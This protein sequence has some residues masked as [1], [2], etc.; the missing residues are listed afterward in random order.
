MVFKEIFGSRE[1]IKGSF[2]DVDI[3]EILTDVSIRDGKIIEREDIIYVKPLEIDSEGKGV[4]SAIKELEK[5]NIV[6]LNIKAVA[7]N[8]LLVNN[9]VRELRVTAEEMDGDI[10]MLSPEKILIVPT[11]V[12][13]APKIEK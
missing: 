12:K 8:K 1:V 11:G 10:A 9:I 7:A 6:V 3:E 13:I 5:G 2:G 4:G